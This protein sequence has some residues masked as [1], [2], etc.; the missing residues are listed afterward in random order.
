MIGA[1]SYLSQPHAAKPSRLRGQVNTPSHASPS[2][3]FAPTRLGGGVVPFW[4]PAG[5]ESRSG[6]VSLFRLT[7]SFMYVHERTCTSEATPRPAWPTWAMVGRGLARIT[8]KR[9][10]AWTPHVGAT[11]LVQGDPS[12]V[13]SCSWP[14]PAA[15]SRWR[16]RPIP[17]R[18]NDEARSTRA[19][20][21]RTRRGAWETDLRFADLPPQIAANRPGRRGQPHGPQHRP[22]ST[23]IRG[24]ASARLI[25]ISADL[26]PQ[27][28]ANRPAREASRA[29]ASR[30][31]ASRTG[32][33]INQHNDPQRRI[34]KIRPGRAANADPAGASAADRRAGMASFRPNARCLRLSGGLPPNACP[35]GD[36][37]PCS[38][39]R[40]SLAGTFIAN[41]PKRHR[42]PHRAAGKQGANVPAPPA[43]P[44]N[45]PRD[46]RRRLG[47]PPAAANSGPSARKSK[48]R[49]SLRRR[50][51]P[52]GLPRHP[53]S[54]PASLP[55]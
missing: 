52:K 1:H 22:P 44:R 5:G 3:R 53:A 8:H 39:G 49:A 43:R 41:P 12:L 11:L 20:C 15:N 55:P 40:P 38:A 48:Q 7:C 18:H 46:R 28:A 25:L 19:P 37:Q 31:K 26:P 34:R 17:V 2:R 14:A 50:L 13:R 32:R 36:C 30:A 21:E 6:R 35:D 29:K 16:P 45:G 10:G 42:T 51:R 27:N 24:A 9:A 33:S 4:S 47:W 54:P 23:A